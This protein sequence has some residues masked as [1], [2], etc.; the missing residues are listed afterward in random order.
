M[1][2]KHKLFEI[3][4]NVTI[5]WA[6]MVLVELIYEYIWW[7]FNRIE[8]I[9]TLSGHLGTIKALTMTLDSNLISIGTDNIKLWDFNKKFLSGEK[10]HESKLD[11]VSSSL[12]RLLFLPNANMIFGFNEEIQVWDE[13]KC[14]KVYRPGFTPYDSGNLVDL[15][16]MNNN[17]L[18]IS[19]YSRM[20]VIWDLLKEEKI[21]QSQ[22]LQ[23]IFYNTILK[24]NENVFALGCQVPSEVQIWAINEFKIISTLKH[25]KPIS[26][27]AFTENKRQ[28]SILAGS[29]RHIYVWHNV[30]I[31]SDSMINNTINE[32]GDNRDQGIQILSGHTD[33]ITCLLML[34][35]TNHLLSGSIDKTIR[36][37]DIEK[38]I[39]VTMLRAHSASITTLNFDLKRFRFTSGASN[40]TLKVW[41]LF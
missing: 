20:V 23:N 18:L 38:G 34:P 31:P 32:I 40:G 9:D 15:I 12:N 13:V 22:F 39:C 35:E 2:I 27:L 11:K 17:S 41:T 24:I 30:H 37:W 29:D 28:I 4:Q 10:L 36:V 25:G 21:Y 1:P 6:P 3:L 19:L 16:L 7:D 8:C 26:A 14:L 5:N 33:L